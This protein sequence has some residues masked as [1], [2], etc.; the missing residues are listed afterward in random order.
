MP[1]E[2]LL[3]I[4]RSACEVGVASGAGETEAYGM[5]S[6]HLTIQTAESR[7]DWIRRG[8]EEGIGIRA[9]LD[10]RLGFAYSSKLTNVGIRETSAAANAA[11]RESTADAANELP[12]PEAAE[13]SNGSAPTNNLAARGTA[14]TEEKIDLLHRM[15]AAARSVDS[16]VQAAAW[17]TYSEAGQQV[18]V[19]NSLGPAQE[20]NSTY[21]YC[22]IQLAAADGG[23][24]ELG[25]AFSV[26]RRSDELDAEATGA[27]AGLRAVQLLHGRTVETGRTTVVFD[28]LAAAGL[29]AQLARLLTGEA[30]F[31]GQSP[32]AARTGESVAWKD[33]TLTDDP[34]LREAPGS[35]PFDAEG[36]PSRRTRLIEDGILVGFI[37]NVYSANRT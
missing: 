34:F 6:R 14:T 10:R 31:T 17:C 37:H 9:L 29:L 2:P 20:Y 18:A 22:R 21:C 27:E 11:A 23:E 1:H 7:L 26:G 36:V 35:R 28:P 25:Y 4:V 16:R 5:R 12:S 8:C 32:F 13:K 33:L 19:A 30:L 15:E 3:G 24:K